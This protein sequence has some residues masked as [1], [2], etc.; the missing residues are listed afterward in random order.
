MFLSQVSS[1][2]TS[3]DN[4]KGETVAR[5]GVK[6]TEGWDMRDFARWK[7]C[8]KRDFTVN[9]LMYDPFQS[10]VYDYVGG[11]RDLRKFQVFLSVCILCVS[12]FA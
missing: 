6:G 11:L 3:L 8:L 1:F 12:A 9:G 10:I 7:N 4:Q 5:K 2:C